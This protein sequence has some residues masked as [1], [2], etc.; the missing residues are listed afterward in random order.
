MKFKKHLG[1][2]VLLMLFCAVQVTAFTQAITVSG[3][4]TATTGE[5]LPGVS[6][7][8]QGTTNG[9]ITDLDGNYTIDGLG[10]S[11]VLVFSYIG[12]LTQQFTVGSQTTIDVI[13]EE[14]LMELDEIVVIGYG[15]QKK[16]DLTGAVSSLQEGD[17]NKVSAAT[18]EQLIQGRIAGVQITSN[19]GEPGSGAQIRVRGASTI[20][21]GQQPLYVIDGVPL[22]NT[23]SSPDGAKAEGVGGPPASN[24]LNFLSSD[25]I[26]SIS[27]LKDA[28]SAAIYGSRGANGVILITTKK[29]KQGTSRVNYSTTLSFS[30]LPKK[31]DVLSTEDWLRYRVDSLGEDVD[32]ENHMGHSTD[33][34]DEIFRKAVSTS[35]NLSFSGG[36]EKTSYRASFNYSDENG[37]IKKSNQKRYYGRV[38]FTQK[39]IKDRLFVEAN[40]TGSQTIQSRPAIGTNGFQGDIL[41]NALKANPTWSIY[42]S[43]GVDYYQPDPNQRNPVAMLQLTDDITRT[44]RVI[45]GG[46]ATLELFKGFNYKLNVGID[47][48]S[49]NRKS[50]QSQYLAYLA[51]ENG[52]ASI[53]SK[54]L[55]NFLIEHTLNYNKQFGIH[56]IKALLGYSYQVIDNSGYGMQTGGFTTDQI[57]YIYSMASGLPDFTS[58]TSEA[59]TLMELQSYFGRINYNLM[60]KYLFT[61]TLRRDGSSK[62]GKNTKYGNYPS[63]AFAWRLTEEDFMQNMSALSN[64]K[65]RLG[66]GQTGNA[67]IPSDNSTYLLKDDP[68]STAIIN[69]IPVPGYVLDKTPQPLLKWETT[70][71]TN[72][73][74]DWGLYKGRLSGT[75][76]LFNKRTTDLLLEKPTKPL[77]PT[78]KIV[79][80]EELGYVE[81]NGLEL[82]I[83]G[84]PVT[85]N[86][87]TWNINFNFTAIKNNIV[88]ILENDESIIPTGSIQGQGMTGQYAQAYANNQTMASYYLYKVDSLNDLGR[89]VY[90]K[91]PDGSDSLMFMGSALPKFTLGLNN[92]FNYK[93]FDFSFFIEVVYGNKV[94]NNTA[95]LLE[96]S[97]MRQAQNT[98]YA[99]AEDEVTYRVIPRASDRYLEDG[100]FL[101]LANAS[102]GYNLNVSSID[103]IKSLRIYASGYNLFLLTKYTG[104]DPDVSASADLNGVRSIGMDVTNYPKARTFLLGL[105]V[106]F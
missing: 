46:S 17:F 33:W 61:F 100:S 8:V 54:E 1:K 38:N 14:D 67:E 48:T 62:F 56:G 25:D 36:S 78:S 90:V 5:G 63:A 81:N 42:D 105:N 66:W 11:S 47:Y 76:D 3:R 73:G 10:E 39:A 35:H 60:E 85:N 59:A 40:L 29:G 57:Q 18:P 13:L 49:A 102:I 92:S 21:S 89:I 9:T 19:N 96:K 93:N 2:I 83:S 58:V 23:S 94:F 37:I 15:T 74:I 88:D 69:N 44:T 86:N 64:L 91:G 97:N 84:V 103:W 22:D 32:N 75:I 43:T 31:L 34:Q 95:V 79:T 99:F 12:Y 70:T 4:V 7:V 82:A 27:V 71:S 101:R 51:E 77:S 65:I 6:I 26:E 20:R 104:F 55:K 28:S 87:F 24:P 45:G 30:S 41:L 52:R 50:Q 16:S 106:S 80:N 98:L 72:F 68:G 53:N